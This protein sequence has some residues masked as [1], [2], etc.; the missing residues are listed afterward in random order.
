MSQAHFFVKSNKGKRLLVIDDYMFQR[1]GR[2]TT[3]TTYWACQVKEC[4]ATAHTSTVTDALIKQKNNHCHLP[5]PE[6]IEIR[7]FMNKV[8]CRVHVE[9][10]AAGLIYDQ[11]LAKANLSEAALAMA[12][13]AQEARKLKKHLHSN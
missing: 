1:S 12:P 3:V 13:T 4:S 2:I 5:V 7:Q 8:K 10:A 9:T 6:K 11:E